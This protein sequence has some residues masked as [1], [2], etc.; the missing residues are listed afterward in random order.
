MRSRISF[1]PRKCAIHQDHHQ[2]MTCWLPRQRE[3][4]A[5][6]PL[7]G[8]EK[9]LKLVYRMPRSLSMCLPREQ[10]SHEDSHESAH[11]H[12]TGWRSE[13]DKR[14]EKA[15]ALVWKRTRLIHGR[16]SNDWTR[17]DAIHP[18]HARTCPRVRDACALPLSS[19]ES[20]EQSSETRDA[21]EARNLSLL[22]GSPN[23]V[24]FAHQS[25]SH[26]NTHTHT[27]THAHA[28]THTHTHTH[29]S[30]Q[31]CGRPLSLTS[32]DRLWQVETNREMQTRTTTN[33]TTCSGQTAC[34]CAKYF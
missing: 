25:R 27:H 30:K 12:T 26:A 10:D 18:P 4:Q 23:L 7:G 28:H 24:T 17:P 15:Y 11:A 34:S 16:C 2:C 6:L 29:T 21:Y 1:L 19:N 20:R 8:S 31:P 33:K 14:D 22:K 32:T 3:Y 13:T 5:D 9:Q